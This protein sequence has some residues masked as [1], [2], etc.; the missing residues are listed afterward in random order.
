MHALHKHFY[1]TWLLVDLE[2]CIHVNKKLALLWSMDPCPQMGSLN[3]STIEVPE[4]RPVQPNTCIF[5]TLSV[6]FCM[7]YLMGS[8]ELECNLKTK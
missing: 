2:D 1:G 4:I 5:V 3:N 7:L 8:S 6:L